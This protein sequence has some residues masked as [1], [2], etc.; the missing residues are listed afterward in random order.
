MSVLF[1]FTSVSYSAPAKNSGGEATG[2]ITDASFE[3]PGNTFTMISGPSGSGK[4]TLLRLFNRLADP[5]S[6]EISYE[7]K[8]IREIPIIELRKKIGWVPQ[9]PVRFDGSVEDNIRLPFTLSRE[10]RKSVE[11]INEK[12]NEL[13]SME[14]FDEKIFSRDAADL[15]VGEAQRMNLL[16]A[17]ALDP[18]VILLDEPTSALDRDASDVLLAQIIKIQ[19]NRGLNAIMVSHRRE[20][21]EMAGKYIIDVKDGIARRRDSF[22]GK[23]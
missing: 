6:G 22:G 5:S 18:D 4:S 21:V 13:K 16:R 9:V 14:L 8:P 2:I 10:H 7:G 17:L 1:K 23:A 15:S 19:E 20:E 3:I 11:Q 12:L